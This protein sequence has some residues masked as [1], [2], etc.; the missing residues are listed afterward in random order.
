MLR[1]VEE[2]N[3]LLAQG[4]RL[5]VAG[6]A[7]VLE[8]LAKGDWIG[9]SIPYFLT[10]DGGRVDRERAFVTELPPEVEQISIDFVSP[11]RLADVAAKAPGYGFSLIAVP[12]MSDI[13]VR[14]AVE[15]HDLPDI[16]ASPLIGWV[17]GVHLDDLGK[18]KPVVFNGQ[19]GESA[20]DRIVA[21]RAHVTDRVKP[22]IGIINLFEQDS[23]D[24]SSSPPRASP[25]RTV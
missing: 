11:D 20:T 19:T 23:G 18:A 14:Y 22:R 3:R 7:A 13:H 10:A 5:H 9:G 25:R 16:F 21:L 12:A 8:C 1:T 15:A 6:D 24:N 2:V 17:A 4:K